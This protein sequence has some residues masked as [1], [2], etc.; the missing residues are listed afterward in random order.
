MRG[1]GV[2]RGASPLGL[3][4]DRSELVRVFLAESDVESAWREAV[5]GGCSGELWLQL[6]R[7][8]S[9]THPEDA[10]GVDRKAIA[11]LL[12]RTNNDAYRE[13]VVLLQEMRELMNGL[14]RADDFAAYLGAVRTQ[15]KAKRNFVA[16]L[17][18][19]KL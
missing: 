16:L 14:N 17:D 18:K 8:R 7:L 2:G 19:A 12:A 1:G 5:E 3:R 15:H 6:A 4:F 11:A 9:Q 10:I 13:A